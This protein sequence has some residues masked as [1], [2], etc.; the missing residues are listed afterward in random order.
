[1]M[2]MID[3]GRRSVPVVIDRCCGTPGR[4]QTA[5]DAKVHAQRSLRRDLGLPRH[6]I[7]ARFASM[8]SNHED[9]VPAGKPCYQNAGTDPISDADFAPREVGPRRIVR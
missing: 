6:G 5:W 1:M 9:D 2:M 7:A 3:S 8:S 4:A